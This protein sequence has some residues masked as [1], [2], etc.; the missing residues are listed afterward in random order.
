[1]ESV[2]IVITLVSLALTIVLAVVLA[3]LI[4]D[5]RRRSEA[6]VAVLRE[7]ADA[8]APA[9]E[10]GEVQS[11]EPAADLDLPLTV[12]VRTSGDLFVRREPRSAW[13]HRLAVAAAIAS[14]VTM[15]ALALRSTGRSPSPATHANTRPASTQTEGL[16]E[17]LSL[18]QTQGTNKLTIIG[19]VQNPRD[20]TVLSKVKATALLFGPDGTFLASGGAPLDFTLLNPGDE[21]PFVIDVPVTAPVARYRVGFRGEDGR[22][23]GH[24]DRRT[25]ATMAG[26]SETVAHRPRGRS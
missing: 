18:K 26:G 15:T 1:M 20:G 24:V 6:R 22:V 19:L 12:D 21:S 23:I 9:F 17:L 16:L 25:G 13:P 2:L 10:A 8:V 3:R 4:R 7:M 5:E 14:L 11:R